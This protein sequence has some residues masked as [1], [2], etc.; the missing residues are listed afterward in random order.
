MNS[1]RG[2]ISL[3]GA[4]A[5][6]SRSQEA[7]VSEAVLRLN[8]A[9]KVTCCCTPEEESQEPLPDATGGEKG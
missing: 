4:D 5:G 1:A 7:C 6:A 9:G 3:S 8:R 2:R